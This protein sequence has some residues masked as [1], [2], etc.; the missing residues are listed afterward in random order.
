MPG[1][2]PKGRQREGSYLQN[3]YK[4]VRSATVLN[5]HLFVTLVYF[6][7]TVSCMLKISDHLIWLEGFTSHF[8]VVSRTAKT[9]RDTGNA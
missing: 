4:M 7:M 3:L 1:P 9:L 5:G 6:L 8:D 2:K